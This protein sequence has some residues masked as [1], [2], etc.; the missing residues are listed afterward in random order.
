M[1]DE[2]TIEAPTTHPKYLKRKRTIH[3]MRKDEN[4][5]KPTPDGLVSCTLCEYGPLGDPDLEQ[6]EYLTKFDQIYQSQVG[7][8]DWLQLY[9]QLRDFWNL[10]IATP[11]DDPLS[12]IDE[13]IPSIQVCQLQH[14]YD[15]CCRTRNIERILLEQVDDILLVQ[16]NI[17]DN[18]LYVVAVEDGMGGEVE[19]VTYDTDSE[20]VSGSGRKR[21]IKPLVNPKSATQWRE[22]NRSLVYT[23]KAYLDCRNADYPTENPTKKRRVGVKGKGKSPGPSSSNSGSNSAFKDY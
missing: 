2:A 4:F 14:H 19:A 5:L 3:Q 21:K 13:R 22:F 10:Y 18:G 20:S 6:S 7:K 8:M 15:K 12:S 1:A 23:L 17:R 11:L 9:R 16:K